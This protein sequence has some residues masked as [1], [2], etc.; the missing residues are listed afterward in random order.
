M[1]TGYFCWESQRTYC[2]QTAPAPDFPGNIVMVIASAIF[3]EEFR[4]VIK[5]VINRQYT[6]VCPEHNLKMEPMLVRL[7]SI[8][9]DLSDTDILPPP[10]RI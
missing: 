10:A 8:P 6:P 5:V 2:D 9:P 3:E 1:I 4:S 7:E